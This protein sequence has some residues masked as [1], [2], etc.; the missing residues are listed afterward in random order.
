MY[1]PTP[2]T[3]PARVYTTNIIPAC[4]NTNPPTLKNDM[5]LVINDKTTSNNSK[6]PS[7]KKAPNPLGNIFLFSSNFRINGSFKKIS[8]KGT[9]IKIRT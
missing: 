3:I 5:V 6:N 1:S 4:D 7:T 8:S 9:T 2:P